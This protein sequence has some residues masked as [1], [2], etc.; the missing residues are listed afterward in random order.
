[1]SGGNGAG[2]ALRVIPLGGLGEIGLNLLVLEYA[3]TAIAI[4]CGVMF[5]DEQMLGID[6]AIPD[7]T[8]LRTLGEKFRAI[9]LTHG[10]EDHIGALPYVLAER[11]VPVY[12]TPLTLGFVRERLK[13]HGVSATLASYGRAPVDVGPF[14][15]EPFAMTHSIPEAVGLAI[16]TPIGTVVHTGD[17]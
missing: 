14:A 15:V 3:D 7:V 6:V 16:R 17:F 2:T 12:G 11:D 10:H 1:M 5:P 9:F 4:D 13:E 8:Y